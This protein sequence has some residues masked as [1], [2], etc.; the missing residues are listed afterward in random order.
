FSVDQLQQPAFPDFLCESLSRAGLR[1]DWFSW[2]KPDEMPEPFRGLLVHEV[3][4]TS[5]L[6]RHHGEHM[7]L[8]VLADGRAAGY[9]FREVIL[10]GAETGRAAEFGLIEIEVGQFPEDLQEAILSGGIPLGGIMNES[11]MAY[12]S[13]PLGYF[14]VAREKLPTKLSALGNGDTF[15]GRYNQLMRPDGS[16]LARILEIIPRSSDS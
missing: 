2:Y 6:E 13:R 9:Y 11:G 7:I 10:R 5:T 15:Y 1:G 8:E 12:E 16:C 14:S 4:M 3:D